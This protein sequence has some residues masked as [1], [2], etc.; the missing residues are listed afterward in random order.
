MKT[1]WIAAC[2]LLVAACGAPPAQVAPAPVPLEPPVTASDWRLNAETS[3]IAFVSIKAGEFAEPHYFRT[4]AG[5]VTADG[6][7]TL[8][9]PLDS[10]ETEIPIRN[11]RM[12]EMLFETATYPNATITAAIPTAQF[13]GLEIGERVR[14]TADVTVSLHGVERD[15]TTDLF[16]T[17]IDADQVLVETATPIL[18]HADDFDLLDGVSALAEVAGLPSISPSVPVTVSLVFER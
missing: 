1:T 5:E 3:R 10:V 2:L 12:R 16:V 13:E 4:L 8:E 15:I 11:E 14:H 7:A 18:M 17:R 6:A 9:I